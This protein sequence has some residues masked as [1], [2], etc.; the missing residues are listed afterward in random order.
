[1]TVLIVR[2]LLDDLCTAVDQARLDAANDPRWLNALNAGYNWLLQQETILFDFDRHELTVPS[3][4]TE[5]VTYRA[6]GACQCRAFEQHNACWHR[7]AARLVRR[8]RELRAHGVAAAVLAE[9]REQ[10]RREAYDK[11]MACFT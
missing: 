8:S 6:N 7:A 2:D 10:A 1:M 3:A 9:E 11:L 5:G 4:T